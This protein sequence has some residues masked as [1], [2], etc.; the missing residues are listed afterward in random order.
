MGNFSLYGIL[1]TVGL[2]LLLI[3]FILAQINVTNPYTGTEASIWSTI[4]GW[5]IP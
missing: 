5:I 1:I 3:G 4:I 2:G